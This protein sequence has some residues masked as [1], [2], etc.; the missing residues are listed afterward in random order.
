M[1]S[2]LNEYKTSKRADQEGERP[3]YRPRDERKEEQEQQKIGK[4]SSW[5]NR[6]GNEAVIFVP[7]TQNSQQQKKY[8][9]EVKRQGFRIKVV[10]KARIAIK[11][12]LQ[13]SDP[14]KPRQCE[15]QDCSNKYFLPFLSDPFGFGSWAP[16]P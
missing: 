6:G 7:A 8:Q 10:E 4:K 3:L 2:A 9:K 16:D 11:R 15:R 5:Y 1:D 13:K 14:F 12:L